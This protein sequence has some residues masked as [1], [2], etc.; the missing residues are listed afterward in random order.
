MTTDSFETLWAAV[1]KD[2]RLE[3]IRWFRDM[4]DIKEIWI[5][6]FFRDLEM[7][8]LMRTSSL[9]E[10]ENAFFRK[11]KNKQSTL[12]DFFFR[13]EAAIDKQRFN[14]RALEYEMDT[15][16]VKFITR[17]QIERRAHN[18]YTPTVFKLVQKE[19]EEGFHS[20]NQLNCVEEEDLQTCYIQEKVASTKKKL[21]FKV[22]TR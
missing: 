12:V 11:C 3:N 15:S 10:S 2:Y 4:Y 19:M 18:L 5:P 22:H 6:A 17:T 14:Q 21:K 16:S 9:S 7:N 20:C 8:G 13:F 1:I